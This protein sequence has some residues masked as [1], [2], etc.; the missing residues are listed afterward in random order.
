MVKILDFGKLKHDNQKKPPEA[1][2]N[3]KVI[4]I[5]EIKMRPA[6]TSMTTT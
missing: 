5:K 6:S 4:E 3:Q 1:R 2:K